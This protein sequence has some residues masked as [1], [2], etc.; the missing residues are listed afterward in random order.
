[1]GKYVRAVRGDI[2]GA[3][4]YT[5]NDDGTTTD[6]ASGL[7]W[8][9]VDLGDCVTWET[10]LELAEN[11]EYAGYTDW[12]LPDVKE[13]Q[14]IV[15]YSGS[16]PAINQDYFDCTVSEENENFYYWSSTSAY[17]STQA[18]DYQFAWYVAFG[19]T[20]HGAGAVRNY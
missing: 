9:T 8:T 12:R 17:A 13:L 4:D 16:Y 7:M 6:N 5:L 3:E 1:M 14:S 18:P 15:D 2:Y 20:N 19:Y 10:A 11:S